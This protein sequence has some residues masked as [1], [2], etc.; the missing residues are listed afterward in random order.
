M[1]ASPSSVGGGI[2]SMNSFTLF[3]SSDNNEIYYS[4]DIC[5]T[6]M[7]DLLRE[8]KKCESFLLKQR[9]DVLKGSAAKDA[10]VNSGTSFNGTSNGTSNTSNGTSNGTIAIA[11][12]TLVIDSRYFTVSLKPIR[13][14]IQS[15]GGSVFPALALTDQ[16]RLLAVPV[17]TIVSGFCASAATFL[18]LAGRRRY[19]T[20]HSRMLIHEIKAGFWGKMSALVDDLDNMQKLSQLII[21]YYERHTKLTRE[22]LVEILKRDVYWSAEEC[23]E[24]GLIDE[25]I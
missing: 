3:V 5:D 15:H 13:L 22:A 11:T 8:L 20:R 2:L 16:I 24:R 12:N 25:I 1:Q 6:G 9:D 19:M 18:S 23:L 14:T 7:S 10:V 21:S 4:G 17:D